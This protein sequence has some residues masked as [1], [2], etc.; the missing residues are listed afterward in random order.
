[1]TVASWPSSTCFWEWYVFL[2]N[3]FTAKVHCWLMFSLFS[4]M[5]IRYF[6]C[7]AVPPILCC[8]MALFCTCARIW[9]YLHWTS[10]SPCWP[11]PL[12][13]PGPSEWRLC[14]P[15]H[16]LLSSPFCVICGHG[17][18]VIPLLHPLCTTQSCATALLFCSLCELTFFHHFPLE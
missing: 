6:F 12:A 9:I 2:Y 1:M 3:P 14:S 16:Q 7:R 5:T 13:W 15:E 8:W 10:W 11:I 17:E 18:G 4:I